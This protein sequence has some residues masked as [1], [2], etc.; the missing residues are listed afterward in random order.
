MADISKIRLGGVE[1]TIKDAEARSLIAQLGSPMHFV[2]KA[3]GEITEN[4]TMGLDGTGTYNGKVGDVTAWGTK[5]FI[6]DGTKWLELG[7]FGTLGALAYGDTASANYTPTGSVEVDYTPVGTVT[8]DY[9]PAGTITGTNVT[10]GNVGVTS[11][12]KGGDIDVQGSGEVTGTVTSTFTGT[13]GNVNATGTYAGET[14]SYTPTGTVAAP[15]VT[16]KTFTGA[17]S[18]FNGNIDT[19]GI[20]IVT[21]ENVPYVDAL[22]EETSLTGSVSATYD[23]MT[24]SYEAAGETLAI[25]L[26]ENQQATVS[27]T[28]G[29]NLQTTRVAAKVP[30]DYKIK[31]ATIP[32]SVTGTPNGSINVEVAA[33]AFTGG[34]DTITVKSA[35]ISSTGKFKPEGTVVSDFEGDNIDVSASGQVTGTIENTVTQPTVTVTQGTFAGTKAAAN[36]ATF[37]GTKAGT[38][39][40]TFTGDAKKITVNPDPKA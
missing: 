29:L 13:E 3:T 16:T 27:S 7:D 36:I 24:A 35:E 21:E 12:F 9:T 38:D 33:P 30:E 20:E 40:A 19:S 15:A 4:G 14:I 5:E 1:Y 11:V 31:A 6:W 37:A 17:S 10:L 8:V 28:L 32:V 22:S 39:I 23:K 18:T 26:L 2:G 34:K 25:S